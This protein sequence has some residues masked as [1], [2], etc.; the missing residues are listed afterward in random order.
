MACTYGESWAL[1]H[2]DTIAPALGHQSFPSTSSASSVEQLAAYFDP[3]LTSSSAL[4]NS[5]RP[6]PPSR[7]SDS[8]ALPDHTILAEI[9]RLRQE[10]SEMKRSQSSNPAQ[11][12]LESVQNTQQLPT[13]F[14]PTGIPPSNAPPPGPRRNTSS[15]NTNANNLPRCWDPCCNGRTFSNPSNL[16]RHQRE[17][18]GEAAK[19]RCSFCDA[20]FS[21]SA[22]RNAHEAEKRCRNNNSNSNNNNEP[23]SDDSK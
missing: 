8:P 21:R 7:S 23:N 11:E 10:L 5:T 6:S 4:S 22:A 18:R 9:Q 15:N 20:V 13:S 17:K 14:N 19:L 2:S 16:A 3:G 1:F 12:Q